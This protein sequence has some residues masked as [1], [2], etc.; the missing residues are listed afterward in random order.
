MKTNWIGGLLFSAVLI[1]TAPAQVG[2]YIGGAPPP[3][4]VERRGAMPG[5]GYAWVDRYWAPNGGRVSPGGRARGSP[6]R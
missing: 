6:A 2:V 4:R 3:L 1:G 5:P